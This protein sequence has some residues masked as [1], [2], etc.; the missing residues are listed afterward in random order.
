V[1]PRKTAAVR[2]A[3]ATVALFATTLVAGSPLSGSGPEPADAWFTDRLLSIKDQGPYL[4]LMA[5]PEVGEGLGAGRGHQ[6][7]DLFAPPGTPL[8]AADDA[9]VVE[10]GSDG[11]RGNYV[12]IYDRARDRTYSY[13]HMQ[14]PA[15]VASGERVEAG[16]KLGELGCTGSCW[17]DHLHFELRSGRGP[18]GPTLDPVP[19]VESLGP[20]PRGGFRANV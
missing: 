6:G 15:L 3:A 20:A 13:F 16:Q 1:K 12:A 11:G 8:V 14:E 7:V 17:G 2:L 4:P 18:Y 10:T 5:E 19:F 9:V